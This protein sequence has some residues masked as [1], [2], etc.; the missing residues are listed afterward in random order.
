[1]AKSFSITT[2]VSDA[3]RQYAKHW[4]M[5]T[6]AG[7]LVSSVYLLDSGMRG[8]FTKLKTFVSQDLRCSSSAEDFINKVSTYAHS[9]VDKADPIGDN[10]HGFLFSLLALF[11]YLGLVRMCLQL[12][13]KNRSNYEVFF[14]GFWE[15]LRFFGAN[16][17][18]VALGVVFGL[19][20]TAMGIFFAWV[21]L[22]ASVIAL[23]TL[24][25]SII[26][27]VYMLHFWLIA[28]CVVDKSK[29]VLA[30]LGCSKKVTA[31][32]LGKLVGFG[33]L[34]W[35]VIIVTRIGLHFIAVPVAGLVPLQGFEGFLV[36]MVVLPIFVMGWTSVYKQLK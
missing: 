20:I 5:L 24:I 2:A 32:H 10:M 8:H 30:T 26:F 28:W 19:A 3:F 11:M 14:Q 33:V 35:A 4:L 18:L 36:G 13:T 27:M 21:Q 15:Y 12:T 22:S 1:M 6:V 34:F 7:A 23:F 25:L 31:G 16:I 17:I 29:G 9:I